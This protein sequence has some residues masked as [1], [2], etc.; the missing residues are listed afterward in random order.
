M[1]MADRAMRSGAARHF[2]ER[3]NNCYYC[4]I[5]CYFLHAYKRAA[6]IFSA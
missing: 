4:N 5:F 1:E 6:L 3:P 2:H